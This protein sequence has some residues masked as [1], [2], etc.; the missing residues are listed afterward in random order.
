[1]AA[2][3]LV[4]DLS[5]AYFAVDLAH[6]LIFLPG[7]A[8]FVAHHLTTLYVLATNRH[9]AGAGAHALLGLE[10]LAKATSAA[11]NLWTLAG[12]RRHDFR[13]PPRTTPLSPSFYVAYTAARAVL[14]PAWLARMVR[15]YA[16]DSG[17]GVPAWA[18]TSWTVVIGARILLSQGRS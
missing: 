15:F 7:K 9:A 5:T 6:Y 4:L 12:I 1:M 18:W 3:E 13:W 16:S 8:L 2:E 11:Q 14:V 17:S 10:V